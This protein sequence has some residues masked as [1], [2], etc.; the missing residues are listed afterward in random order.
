VPLILLLAAPAFAEQQATFRTDVALVKVDVQVAQGRRLIGDLQKGD[1]RVLDNGEPQEIVYFG[2][3]SEPLSVLLLLDVSGSM[4][5]HVQAMAAAARKA[6]TALRSGDDVALM[7]F[8]R[9]SE[10]LRPFTD[11]LDR[12]Q[13]TLNSAVNRRG[14][15]SGTSMNTSIIEAADY[16]GDELAGNSGRRAIIVLTDNRGWNYATPDQQVVTALWRAE[17]VLNAIVVG[18]ARPPEPLGSD[19]VTNDDFTPSNIFH[20][21]TATGGDIV[22]AQ[23]AGTAFQVLLE[24]IRTRYSLHYRAPEGAPDSR[25]EILVELAG[26]AAKRYRRA[27]VRARSGYH[28][29]APSER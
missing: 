6:M 17:T 10:L 13:R 27:I 18:G 9:E 24:G 20:L 23:N 22:R 26:D 8:S 5:K 15:G 2:R 21:A 16:I 29:T 28:L 12:I 1:F 25:R 7:I 14:L 4:R 3:E 19:L 11:D